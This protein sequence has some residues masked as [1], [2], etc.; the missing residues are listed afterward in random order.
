MQLFLWALALLCAGAILAFLF[1]RWPAVST[2]FG[3]AAAIAGGMAGF[4]S[5]MRVFFRGGNET[6]VLPWAIPYGSFS[7]GLDA[8]SAV[9]LLPIF[10]LSAIAAVYGAQYLWSYRKRKNLGASWMFYNLLTVG[11]AMVVT[12]RNGMLFLVV[13]EVMSIASFFLVTFEEEK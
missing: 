5:A 10:A 6:L 11:M 7:L 13:W 3:V 12:A 8:L 4:V 9:F 2:F 1:S